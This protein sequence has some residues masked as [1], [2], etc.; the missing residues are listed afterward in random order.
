MRPPDEAAERWWWTLGTIALLLLIG[1]PAAVSPDGWDVLAQ[2]AGWLEGRGSPE[3]TARWPPLWTA[4]MVPGVALDAVHAWGRSLN[5]VLAGAVAWP[6]YTLT[7][8]AAGPSAARWAVLVWALVPGVRHLAVI[9]DARPLAW[10]LVAYT[11]LWAI[12]HH[13]GQRGAAWMWI[14][15]AL[16]PLV[17]PEG[18]VLPGVLAV[19]G[20]VRGHGWRRALLPAALALV[21]KLVLA[22]GVRGFIEI[23]A[24]FGTW[25]GM[26]SQPDLVALLG[27][28]TVETP[29]RAFL[30][31]AVGAGLEQPPREFG[32]LVRALPAAL[33]FLG[34]GV[35]EAAGGL[36]ALAAAAG[37]GLC[38]RAGGGARV[39]AVAWAVVVLAI[40]LVPMSRGQGT[41]ATNFLWLVP[42]GLVLAALAL[43]RLGAPQWGWPLWAALVLAETHLSPARVLPAEFVESGPAAML[44]EAHLRQD[45]PPLGRVAST[46]TGKAVVLRAGLDH[47]S[48]P[49]TWE[50]WRPE[51]GLGALVSMADAHGEDGGRTLALVE[52]PR[53]RLVWVAS[54]DVVRAWTGTEEPGDE[55]EGPW[56]ALFVYEG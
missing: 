54:D 9:L 39:A 55:A 40:G 6:L 56:F 4:L 20:L 35:V 26:W 24:F 17:R 22:P 3:V 8:T 5:L 18:L 48:L 16:A 31:E 28:T 15:A 33:A 43:A 38:V 52:D 30:A 53:W 37:L 51:P 14:G 29:F 42:G 46:L 27:P 7:R 13:R 25:L 23:E 36:A 19:A 1:G 45:P 49:T 12:E 2:A 41:A 32:A 50:H 10:C 47:E 34:I 11:A 44:A 21:P